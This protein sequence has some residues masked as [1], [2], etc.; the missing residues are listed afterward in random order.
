[1]AYYRPK[2]GSVVL[3]GIPKKKVREFLRAPR[4]DYRPWKEFSSKELI[5]RKDTLEVRP[6]IWKKLYKHQRV[7]FLIGAK[8]GRF[9][10][11]LDTGSGK[12]LLSIALARWFRRK[13]KIKR[14]LVLVPYGITA[15]EWELEV[16]KHSPQTKCAVMDENSSADK[17]SQLEEGKA[18]FYVTTYMGLVRMCSTPTK[19]K[20]RSGEKLILQAGLVNRLMK[21]V[22]GVVLDESHVVGN[23]HA[24]AFRICRQLRKTAKFFFELT[25]TPFGRDPTPLWAQAFLVDGGET[26]GPTLGLFRAAFFETKINFWGGQEHKFKKGLTRKLNRLLAHRSIRYEADEAVMPRVVPITIPV[27]LPTDA[28]SYYQ[29]LKDG[30]REARGNFIESKNLFMRMRQLSSGFI[31][32][33]DDETGN[34]AQFKFDRNPKL[35]QLIATIQSIRED[36][37][38]VVA[39]DFNFSGEEISKALDK[40]G[41]GHVSVRGHKK[42][43]REARRKFERDPKCR[44]F[45]CS[46]AAAY[47]LNLQIAKYLV[48]Y[49]SPVPV[50]L[51]KQMNRRVERQGSKHKR[52][53]IIDLVVEGTQDRRILAFH[54][55]GKDLFEEIVEGRTKE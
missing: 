51:R 36:Y 42:G 25:G 8:L 54:K 11:F 39:H 34:R 12:T 10:F 19:V 24:L 6:P 45:V 27:K 2:P 55:Q 13:E 17:W 31:G 49:E 52:V 20:G 53:F 4:D 33:E 32:Y 7:C 3:P 21:L 15:A 48:F 50:I 14:V 28:E 43:G 35:E 26:L 41:I 47:G 5:R 40:E 22:D 23:K 46:T 29:K 9:L 44:V 18:F 37:K 16:E 38:I 1:M 30:L